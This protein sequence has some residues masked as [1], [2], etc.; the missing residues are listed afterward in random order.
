MAAEVS[1]KTK[2]LLARMAAAY[3]GKVDSV[4]GPGGYYASYTSGDDKFGCCAIKQSNIVIV[5]PYGTNVQ[6]KQKLRGHIDSGAPD[7]SDELKLL[8]AEELSRSG[9]SELQSLA[10]QFD[11]EVRRQA[12]EP[13]LTPTGV[14]ALF[15]L[16]GGPP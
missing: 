15:D 10:R 4:V 1:N 16:G 13:P 11:A 12:P 5:H 6:A 7:E 9:I 2:R 3:P 8:F 14:K